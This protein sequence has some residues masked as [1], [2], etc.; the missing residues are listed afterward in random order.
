MRKL[1]AA[2]LLT[3]IFIGIPTASFAAPNDERPDVVLDDSG[4]FSD[5]DEAKI[6]ETF[7][8]VADR[9]GI[10]PV[11]EVIQTL[12]GANAESYAIDRANELGVGDADADNGLYILVV[13]KDH[14]LRV[15][16]GEGLSRVV[17]ASE[18]QSAIDTKFIPAF[19]NDAYATG[20]IDGVNAIG[21]YTVTE[22]APVAPH[23]PIDLTPVLVTLGVIGGVVILGVIIWVT[24]YFIIRARRR[25][26][27]KAKAEREAANNTEVQRLREKM[28]TSEIFRNTFA[29]LRSRKE[30][31]DSLENE[32]RYVTLENQDERES[33]Y[34]NFEK[35]FANSFVDYSGISGEFYKT[36]LVENE[37]ISEY[38]ARVLAEKPQAEEARNEAREAE[39]RRIAAAE[40]RKERRDE[41]RSNWLALDSSKQEKFALAERSD[42]N[43]LGE[44]YLSDYNENDKA[45]FYRSFASDHKR[46]LEQSARHAFES[47]PRYERERIARSSGG[48]REQYLQQYIPGFNPAL[49]AIYVVA[50]TSFANNLRAEEARAAQQR[51]DD[52]FGSYSS[53]SSF[54][55]G[56]FGG[57]GGG[58]SW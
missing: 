37:S 47:L 11:V 29:N 41:A 28:K 34:R 7:A 8:G 20:I 26:A 53:F 57:G 1:L 52:S 49:V 58:G 3:F 5:S 23:E 21:N 32:L 4:F 14:E 45:E 38:A 10:L 55:G 35:T 42:Q 12:N 15:E 39:R 46:E 6:T 30:R 25:A 40:A 18:I 36:R 13:V 43:L 33:L 44:R 48:T 31:F 27:A 19:K 17:S 24:V 22:P 16:P 9:F 2:L 56:S 50:A 51:S 54:G